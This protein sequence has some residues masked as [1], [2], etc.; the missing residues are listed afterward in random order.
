MATTVTITIPGSVF[1]DA[2]DPLCSSMAEEMELPKPERRKRGKGAQYL[3]AGITSEQ[4]EEVA[5]YLHDRGT[6]LMYGTDP[7]LRPVYRAAIRT[8]A[9][10]REQVKR[11]E[12]MAR[13]IDA[14]VAR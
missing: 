2:L 12:L 13:A 7:E 5:E 3:Y 1:Y 6:G 10:I 4:A 14:P 11:A 8:A 9:K